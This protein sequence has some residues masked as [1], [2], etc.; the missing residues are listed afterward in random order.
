[1]KIS[2]DFTWANDV[3]RRPIFDA[4]RVLKELLW[5]LAGSGFLRRIGLNF[6]ALFLLWQG[7]NV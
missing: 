1:M 6:G 2:G 3:K 7:L 4:S 5:E